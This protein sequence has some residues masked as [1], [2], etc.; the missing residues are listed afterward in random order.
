MDVKER[1]ER[2]RSYVDTMLRKAKSQTE[3]NFSDFSKDLILK[4]T[5][6]DL[7]FVKANGFRGIVL[8]AIVGKFLNP[9]YDPI[10]DFY[11]CNPRSIF[12]QGIWYALRE[13][14]IPSG[15]SDPLNVAKNISL[16]D[17]NWANGK[18]PESAAIAA[19][20]FLRLLMSQP[21]DKY[22]ALVGYFF[23][24]LRLYAESVAAIEIE[25]VSG[26]DNSY[27]YAEKVADFVLRFPEAGTIPQYIVGKLLE[28]L[29]LDNG[30]TVHGTSESVFGTNTTSKKPA[31]IWT[32]QGTEI[33]N[34]YEVTVKKIDGK[35][36]DDCIDSL[37]KLG[38]SHKPVTFICRVPPDSFPTLRD[39]Q[40]V[41]TYKNKEFY[42]VDIMSFIFTSFAIL[43]DTKIICFMNEL[44]EFIQEVN[45]PVITKEGW[46]TIFAD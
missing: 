14:G 46:K 7:I 4:K 17:E 40:G 43:S 20:N 13:N 41:A 24:Q 5:L 29:N 34:L 42:V 3:D 28:Y 36:L 45:R 23:Y 31:D 10:N 32:Q 9:N 19:V 11:A 2:A 1:N 16:L 21:S 26:G 12:E 22:L 27:K 35:R 6:D 44:V 30:V 18:R 38:I 39:T 8:T 15:K 25:V 37:V 33:L